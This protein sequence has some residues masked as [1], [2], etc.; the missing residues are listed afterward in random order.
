MLAPSALRCGA[1]LVASSSLLARPR[2]TA[3]HAEIS[4]SKFS[5][6]LQGLA[7][8]GASKPEI[9]AAFETALQTVSATP[10][11]MSVAPKAAS[12]SPRRPATITE[13]N[14]AFRASLGGTPIRSP[15]L[16]FAECMIESSCIWRFEYDRIFAVGFSALCT[17]FLT[18]CRSNADAD[19]VRAAMCFALGLEDA[20]VRT[21]A[22]GL[23]AAAAG[24]SEAELFAS[25]DFVKVANAAGGFKYTYAFGV[26]LIK[27]MKAVGVAPEAEA[28]DRW[29]V[30]VRGLS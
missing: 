1:L 30:A 9:C 16:K 17:T 6:Y 21:D 26:G 13:A 4:I 20:D 11:A 29:C 10:P 19:A 24:L 14:R 22:A 15:T 28:I 7:A 2:C 5:A 8:D 18:S 23:C 3:P 12:A 25:D 27:L